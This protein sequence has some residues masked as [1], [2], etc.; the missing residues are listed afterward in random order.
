MIYL[1]PRVRSGLGEDTFWTWFHREFPES[2]FDLPKVM[3]DDDILLQYS[4]CG[5]P[6]IPGGRKVGLFWELY[7]EMRKQLHNSSWD[8]IIRATEACAEGCD[9]LTT[10]TP[11][12]Q[13]F[14]EQFGKMDILPIGIDEKLFSPVSKEH[15]RKKH[16]FNP[17]A[18]IGFWCGTQHPMKGFDILERYAAQHPKVRWIVVWKQKRDIRPAPFAKT[19]AQVPQPRLVELMSAADFFLSCSRLRPYYIVEWEAMLCNL[20]AVQPIDLEKEFT[21]SSNP[22]Q[23]VL[24]KKW[25]RTS[26]KQLW[27]AY[28]ER[29]R[30]A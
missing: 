7:P 24:N 3:R 1:N 4:L 23:D 6:R 19:Y 17:S 2:S 9:F 14:Y 22:R 28:L 26:A 25:D 20:P 18:R 16:G 15:V 5:A 30:K 29:I 10:H 21:P 13:E 11:V 8:K 27:A 12:Q